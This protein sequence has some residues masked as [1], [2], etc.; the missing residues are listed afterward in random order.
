MN[1]GVLVTGGAGYIGSIMTEILLKKGFNIVVV[2]DLTEGKREAVCREAVFFENDYG[3]ENFL[4]TLFDHYKFSFIIHLAASANVPHSITEP[5]IYYQNNTSNT[6]SLLKKM[7]ERN[8]KNIIFSSTASIYGE[9]KYT[10]IDEEHPTIPIN[11]YGQ[12][13]LMIEQIIKDCSKAF[14][15]NYVIFRYLC[16]AGATELHGEARHNETHLIPLVV[17]AILNKENQINVYG[18]N[19]ETKDGTGV[20]DYFHVLDIVDAHL[21]AIKKM[22]FIKNNIFNLG[23]EKGYSV[24]E[25]IKTSEKLF[26]TK[27][28]YKIKNRRIGDP[29]ILIAKTNKAQNILGW[30]AR[31]NLRSI[32]KSTYYWQKNKKY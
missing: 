27:I 17:N 14:G 11:P 25:I 21:L 1:Q 7:K 2:D 29:A 4:D 12:S 19:F 18:N 28:N 9:P 24:L 13:K 26:N 3:D 15:L 31:R 10:P 16:V 20:R 6:V 30:N 8:I 22:N 5:L 23:Q 32:I